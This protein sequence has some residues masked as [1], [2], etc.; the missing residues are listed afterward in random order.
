MSRSGTIHDKNGLTKAGRSWDKHGQRAGT[1][2]PKAV[3][4]IY[5]K[6]TRGQ[7]VLDEILNHPRKIISIRSD[8]TPRMGL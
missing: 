8:A 4:N 7:R 5:E 2:F 3:G 6:N 1:V